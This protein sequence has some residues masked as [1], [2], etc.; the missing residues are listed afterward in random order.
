MAPISTPSA[1]QIAR[2]TLATKARDVRNPATAPA[3]LKAHIHGALQQW[4]RDHSRLVHIPRRAQETSG[5]A[6]PFGHSSRD[7]PSASSGVSL[8][9]AL[10]EVPVEAAEPS[11]LPVEI[12]DL[13]DRLPTA[14]AAMIRLHIL[15][16]VAH[17][18]AGAQQGVFHSTAER[19]V[20]QGR[21]SQ[22]GLLT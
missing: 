16:N 15:E 3:F 6:F 13:L 8:L 4:L 14:Q 22:R 17:R 9:E 19:R 11:A 18:A 5:Y 2:L 12:E 7:A 10:V 20:K 21:A 1:V